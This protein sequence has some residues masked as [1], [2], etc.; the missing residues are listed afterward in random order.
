[1][2]DQRSSATPGNDARLHAERAIVRQVLRHDRDPRWSLQ[3]LQSEISN[4]EPAVLSDALENL[5]WHG[6]IVSCLHDFLASRCALR[7]VA[8]G[9]V[10]I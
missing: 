8:L 2:N 4:V 10:T 9:V 3:E 6:V 5:I 1:M 7:L